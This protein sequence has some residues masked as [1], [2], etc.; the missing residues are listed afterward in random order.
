MVQ[1]A[2]RRTVYELPS[3]FRGNQKPSCSVAVRSNDSLLSLGS[4]GSAFTGSSKEW[5]WW[6]LHRLAIVSGLWTC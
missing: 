6:A 1:I 5:Y 3:G 4:D 2:V